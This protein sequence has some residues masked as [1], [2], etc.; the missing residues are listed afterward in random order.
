MADEHIAKKAVVYAIAGMER[1]ATRKDS[2]YRTTDSGPLTMDVYYPADASSRT[3]LPAVVI[4]AGYSDVGAEKGVRLQVQGDGDGRV[5]GPADGRVGVGRDRLHQQGAG[6]RPRGPATARSQ[7]RGGAR[8]D[9]ERIG[10]WACSGSVPLALS[11]LMKH[12]RDF[13]KCGALL[14]G[15]MLDLDGAVGVAQAATTFRFTNP[16]A[17]TS[18]DD[19]GEDLPLLIARA[20]QEQFPGLN[21]SIDRF[22]AQALALN[23]PVTLINHAAGPHAFDLLDDSASSRRIVRQVLDFLTAQL[24]PPDSPD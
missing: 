12:G 23:R 1:A 18:F 24:T 8:I 3:P 6:R 20:G 7:Q 13:L 14:Y 2:V 10:V 22:F 21:D 15:Y 5:V 16:H 9:G 11:A 17:G 19:L 4:V